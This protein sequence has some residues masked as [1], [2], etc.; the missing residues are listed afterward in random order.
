MKRLTYGG[1]EESPV[2]IVY[3]FPK[4]WKNSE[5]LHTLVTQ[6]RL[7]VVV[8]RWQREGA[9]FSRLCDAILYGLVH[10]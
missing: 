10:G 2:H 7:I 4:S 6:S 3:M 1:G 9:N 8:A 5:L